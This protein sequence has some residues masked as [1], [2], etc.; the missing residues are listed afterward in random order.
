MNKHMVAVLPD[1]TEY[2]ED[3]RPRRSGE[4]HHESDYRQIAERFVRSTTL[5]TKRSAPQ[6][7]KVSLFN[8]EI[9]D[10]RIW[11][12]PSYVFDVLPNFEPMTCAE[13]EAEMT[14]ILSV[15][16]VEFH[17]Y[18]R[19]ASY[20]DGHSVGF[21]EA[22]SIARAMVYGLQPVIEQY[23]YRLLRSEGET[24]RK[25]DIIDAAVNGL[26]EYYPI[27]ADT[28]VAEGIG[29][30]VIVPDTGNDQKD[31][32]KVRDRIEKLVENI[33][34]AD[35]S[36]FTEKRDALLTTLRTPK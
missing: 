18:V 14:E 11:R 22:V 20:N 13:Y 16:P 27:L 34:A 12:T 30:F 8:E 29:K 15:L 25:K 1:G 2:F 10:G 9:K 4:R 6:T 28:A 21:E 23:K 3:L 17:A 36:D 35:S 7:V 32:K 31:Y 19:D 5:T 24:T 33:P 26:R